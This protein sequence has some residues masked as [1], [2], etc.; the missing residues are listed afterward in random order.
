[1]RRPNGTGSITELKGNRR[2]KY[3]VRKTAG[4]EVDHENERVVQK[5]VVIGYASTKKEAMQILENYNANPYDINARKLTFA[6]LYEK[7]YTSKVG[8]V[9]KSS[10]DSYT[11]SFKNCEPL[12]NRVFTDLKLGDLQTMIDESDKNY[13][14]LKKVVTLLKLMYDYA[15][16]FD[17][18]SK[19]YS[20]YLDLSKK[21]QEHIEKADDKK[22]F[23]HD[24]VRLLWSERE[25]E[26]IQSILVLIWT[27]LRINEFLTLKKED[28][29]I[30]EKWFNIVDGKTS[31]S[32]RKMPIADIIY[33]YFEKWYHDGECEYLYHNAKD[34]PIKYDTYLRS[35]KKVMETFSMDYTPH[36][37]RHTFNSLLA[38]LEIYSSTRSRLMGHAS[39]NVTETVY[40]HLDMSVLFKA[41][42][43]LE[44]ILDKDW[45]KKRDAIRNG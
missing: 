35:Y 17:L 26:F 23:T 25:D 15:M 7:V 29:N 43:Q 20:D 27:G 36:A 37:T 2:N 5:Q 32:I 31:N 19:D 6:E 39:G 3:M 38:D 1:M 22:H 9:S 18:V 12:H 28:V 44:L 30:E 34:Q 10:L 24:E 40:T 4:M 11:Y 42:N 45:Q 21:K 13:P 14:T 41:V 33:P 8:N 16:K